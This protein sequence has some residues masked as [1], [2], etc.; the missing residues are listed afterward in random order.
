VH[1]NDVTVT[2][3]QKLIKNSNHSYLRNVLTH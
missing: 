1:V 3:A 2:A